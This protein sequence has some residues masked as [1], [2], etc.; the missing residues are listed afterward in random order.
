M[1]PPEEYVPEGDMWFDHILNVTLWIINVTWMRWF[2]LVP[3]F[4]GDFESFH[5]YAVSIN[6]L[7]PEPV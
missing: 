5:W 2:L 1:N 7:L 6:D 4:F 3:A